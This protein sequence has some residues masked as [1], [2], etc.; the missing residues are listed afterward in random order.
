M[1]IQIHIKGADMVKAGWTRVEEEHVHYTVDYEGN[2]VPEPYTVT[3]WSKGDSYLPSYVPG[4][5]CADCNAWGTNKALFDEL[6][7]LKLP[8][9]L[10]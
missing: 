7:L 1:G 2:E 6:G 10:S 3:A 9:I 5:F 8:H 4:A